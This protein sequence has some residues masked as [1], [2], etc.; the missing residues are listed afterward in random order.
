MNREPQPGVES[1][2]AVLKPFSSG[3]AA[4]GYALEVSR[5]DSGGLM[6]GDSGR[7]RRLRRVPDSQGNVRGDAF[8]PA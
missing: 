2:I 1:A 4:N 5:T 8:V 7:T 6:V 3:L